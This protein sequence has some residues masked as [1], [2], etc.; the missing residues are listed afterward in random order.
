MLSTDVWFWFLVD[1]FILYIMRLFFY[2]GTS[3]LSMRIDVLLQRH[4]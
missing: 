1:N 3:T 2:D 4:L